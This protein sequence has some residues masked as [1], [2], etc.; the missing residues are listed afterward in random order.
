L[1]LLYGTNIANARALNIVN[2]YFVINRMRESKNERFKF[3]FLKEENDLEVERMA[4]GRLFHVC[5][6]ATA[7][8]RSPIDV[9]V[10]V[11]YGRRRMPLCPPPQYNTSK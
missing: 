7:N 11:V 9:D 8:A 6:P 5:G 3:F 1:V 2:V 4:G 10:D